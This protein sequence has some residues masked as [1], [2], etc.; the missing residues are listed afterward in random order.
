M[1][2]A[3]TH[4]CPEAATLVSNVG[5]H[6]VH[7]EGSISYLRRHMTKRPQD[8]KLGRDLCSIR[9]LRDEILTC[10][11]AMCNLYS[12]LEQVNDLA[13]QVE[14]CPDYQPQWPPLEARKPKRKSLLVPLL[15]LGATLWACR[16]TGLLSRL[17]QPC[18][19]ERS[20]M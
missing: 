18:Q 15:V 16:T 17:L 11:Q 10:A 14:D 5:Q 3:S 12:Q 13:L 8:L 20:S 19:L 4:R 7:L 6:L 9:H 1:T 2:A